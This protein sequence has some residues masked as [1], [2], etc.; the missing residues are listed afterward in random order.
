MRG[1]TKSAGGSVKGT[2]AG[3]ARS[4]GDLSKDEQV[5]LE[6]SNNKAK[7]GR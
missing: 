7:P 3:T 1:A 2:T 4:V 5:Q 6:R